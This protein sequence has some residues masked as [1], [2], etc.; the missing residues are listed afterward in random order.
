MVAPDRDRLRR[1]FGIGRAVPPTVEPR[2]DVRDFLQ[3]RRALF[4]REP[5]AL[6]AL[7]DGEEVASPHGVFWRRLLRYPLSHRHGEVLLGAASGGD[8][9]K[10][11]ALAK[12]ELFVGLELQRCLFVD[13]ETTGLG[14]GAGTVVFN[15]G[16]GWFD[17]DAFVLEQTFLRSF[18]EEL[19]MLLHVESRLRERP[20]LVTYVGK[21]FDRHRIAARMAVH[22]LSDRAVLSEQHL[23][24]YHLARRAFGRELPDC[25]LRTVEQHKLGLWRD[26]DLPG[27]EAPQAF[28][29]WI[30][31]R[32]GPVDRVLEHNRLD[33]LSVA[34]LLAV[35]AG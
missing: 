18:G 11:A 13:T 20:V 6:V 8:L 19:A 33:V 14:G 26:D 31:D 25:R 1:A 2:L 35:L 28:L 7:P 24:L 4:E 5:R 34:A 9:G 10:L 27:S 17:G 22:K 15:F 3:R 16:L 29:D 32:T 30:R 23:D 21:S 12:S